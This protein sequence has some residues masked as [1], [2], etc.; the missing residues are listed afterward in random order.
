[1]NNNGC[2]DYKY[3]CTCQDCCMAHQANECDYGKPVGQDDWEEVCY[4]EE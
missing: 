1:M 4:C 3:G 2:Q